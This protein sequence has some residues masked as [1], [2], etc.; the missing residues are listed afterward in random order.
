VLWKFVKNGI[1]GLIL[2]ARL[3]Y[4]MTGAGDPGAPKGK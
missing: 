4:L 3:R 1:A 2:S